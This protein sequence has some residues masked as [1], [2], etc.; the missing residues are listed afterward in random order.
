LPFQQ[1]HLNRSPRSIKGLEKIR[2]RTKFIVRFNRLKKGEITAMKRLKVL[3]ILV[4][5]LALTGFAN[6]HGPAGRIGGFGMG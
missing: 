1:F 4:A 6:P 3:I 5:S 2:H